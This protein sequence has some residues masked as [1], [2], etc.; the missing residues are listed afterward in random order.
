MMNDKIFKT[1]VGIGLLIVISLC[2]FLVFHENKSCADENVVSE[3]NRTDRQ[4]EALLEMFKVGLQ[5]SQLNYSAEGAK[6]T[7]VKPEFYYGMVEAAIQQSSQYPEL[8]PDFWRVFEKHLNGITATPIAR[9]ELIDLF[10]QQVELCANHCKNIE[11]Y[12]KLW[13]TSEE[14]SSYR[15][16]LI[17]SEV[18]KSLIL[19]EEAQKADAKLIIRVLKN[20][21]DDNKTEIDNANFNKATYSDLQFSYIFLTEYSSESREDFQKRFNDLVETA[22]NQIIFDIKAKYE[23][24]KSRFNALKDSCQKEKI[25]PVII[26]KSGKDKIEYGIGVSHQLLLDIQ[27]FIAAD[28]NA[29]TLQSLT[30]ISSGDIVELQTNTA[31][32]LEKTRVLNQMIYNLWANRVVYNADKVSQFDRMSMV[33]VEFLYPAVASVYN[34]KMS[35]IMMEIKNPN[36]LSSNIYE[37]ILKDKAPLSAF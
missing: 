17:D 25:D 34:D 29:N 15:K 7:E 12:N 6:S 13:N 5:K 22:G 27:G 20:E 24:L 9:I 14:I 35:K 4:G 11:Q 3:S 10:N 33:S 16:K 30:N 8:I 18:E 1:I 26:E 28:L 32:L 19:L 21:S 37:M 23:G 2:G 36:Q 31:S